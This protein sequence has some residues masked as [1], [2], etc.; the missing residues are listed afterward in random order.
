MEPIK[1]K[2]EG[3]GLYLVTFACLSILTL[4]EVGLTQVRF[5][6]S[7]VVGLIMLIA[8]IQAT[9]VLLYNMQ[10]K[11]HERALKVFVGVIFTLM[12]F[13]IIITMLDYIYR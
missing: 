4:L 13:L 12:F 7:L 5:T 1:K 10:L 9:I 8:V 2:L 11:F 6:T 3:Y